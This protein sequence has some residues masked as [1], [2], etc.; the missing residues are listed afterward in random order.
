M[1]Q[2]G[3]FALNESNC[4][5]EKHNLF[6]L[7]SF[8]SPPC[9]HTNMGSI[10]ARSVGETHTVTHIRDPLPFSTVLSPA[11]HQREPSCCQTHSMHAERRPGP[12]KLLK[13][14]YSRQFFSLYLKCLN[15][16]QT[17]QSSDPTFTSCVVGEKG[18]KDTNVP[19]LSAQLEALTWYE[20]TT[21]SLRI[22]VLKSLV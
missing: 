6:L 12:V 14:H 2:Q 18:V 22:L 7:F 19:R 11:H 17:N 4:Q 20:E 21:K 3:T 16:W 13:W 8:F 10:V 5:C 1:R 15:V 9:P